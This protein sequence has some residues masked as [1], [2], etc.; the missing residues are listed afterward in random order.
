[1]GSVA[2]FTLATV[3]NIK[4]NKKQQKKV[5][6]AQEQQAKVDV[7]TQQEQASKARRATIREAMIK[8][9]QIENVAGATGQ[10]GSTAA[11]AGTSQV[12]S[13][14]TENIGNINTNLNLAGA[15]TRAQQSL[16]NAQQPSLVQQVS[17]AAQQG[18]VLFK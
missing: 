11:T 15:A 10:T 14:L 9:A 3:V 8:R 6:A 17:G 1:M 12:Q 7:A 5:E 16:F 18:A 13:Q 2:V 4:A